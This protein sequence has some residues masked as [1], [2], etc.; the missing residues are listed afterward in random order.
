MYE[1]QKGVPIPPVDHGP[2]QRRKYPFD[3]ME[4]GDMFFAPGKTTATISAHVSTVAK[5]LNRKFTTRQT[6]MRK[7]RSGWEAC[8]PGVAGATKGV[9]VWRTK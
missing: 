7:T 1:V 2:K 6:V 8:Q 4:V 3:T 9:G 5:A